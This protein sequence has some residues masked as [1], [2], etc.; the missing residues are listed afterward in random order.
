MEVVPFAFLLA[1]TTRRAAEWVEARTA[2]SAATPEQRTPSYRELLVLAA[3]CPLMR[4]EGVLGSVLVTTALLLRS[5]GHRARAVPALLSPLLPPLVCL[6]FTGQAL[7]S[8]ALAK[9]L[10][11]NPYYQGDRLVPTA[12]LDP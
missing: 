8:T 5:D 2:P 6:L 10:P 1:R 3:L 9:W 11:L 4:P 7:T 12:V